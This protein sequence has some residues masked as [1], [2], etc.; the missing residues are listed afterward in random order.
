MKK[1]KSKK[2]YI[3]LITEKKDI[4]NNSYSSFI[5]RLR[6]LSKEYK[7][8][9]IENKQQTVYGIDIFNKMKEI[10]SSLKKL[11]QSIKIKPSFPLDRIVK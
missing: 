4:D 5:K 1:D 3:T 8:V 7:K 6:T 11:N 9:I 2:R 10:E